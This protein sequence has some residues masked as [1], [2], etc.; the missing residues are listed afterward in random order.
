LIWRASE[1]TSGEVADAVGGELIGP[2]DLRIAGISTDTRDALTDSLFVALRGERFDA[3][4]MI[5]DA[6]ARGAAALL[7]QR[8]ASSSVPTI[9]VKDTLYA[10][11]E[12]AKAHFKRMNARAV[13]L[14]GS[15][16]KTTTK[17]ML[18]AILSQG[19]WTLKT[20]GNLN[21]LIGL[22]MTIL[23]L[24]KEHEV[25]VIEMGMN[26]PGEIARYTEIAQP[27]VG[28]VI[29]V[30]PAHIGMLGS[31]EAIARAKGELYRGLSRDAI[32]VVNADDPHVVKAA[33]ESPA[34]ARLT[35]G[36]SE[37]AGVRLIGS[38]EHDDG[39]KI[40]VSIAGAAH[41]VEVPFAGEHNAMNATAAIA[42]AH[43]MG[44]PI[45]W[46]IA[47]L[48]KAAKVARRL[49]V[50][51]V[52]PYLLV[53][54][55]YNANEASMAAALK[56]VGAR[57]KREGRRMIALLGEMRELGKFSDEYHGVVGQIAAESGAAV[58]AA[59]GPLARPIADAAMK[60]GAIAKHEADDVE[61]L[62][63]W[64]QGNLRPRDVILV[65]GSR[66]IKMERF[67]ERLKQE[68]G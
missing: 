62:F 32:A 25:A 49:A 2:A 28:M 27:S 61:K 23:G 65:K 37:G 30:G 19:K 29:N 53:D 18:A 42:A 59:F 7:V 46:A 48:P 38:V 12:L 51:T 66:G 17:E 68:I 40:T 26:T 58:V 41:E 20:E 1:W 67:I 8:E 64:L 13:A 6:I 44:V 60:H 50:E 56:T 4:D 14:T 35:F 15:N 39:Q 22:P 16:G 34:E 24:T 5:A 33:E 11:G 43:A 47:G 3:H 63:G 57:A 55:C 31:L 9:R 54:D 45:A 21:N 52:G 10:L 36:R